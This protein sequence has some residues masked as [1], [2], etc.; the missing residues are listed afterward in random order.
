MQALGR[1]RLGADGEDAP[2]M[3]VLLRSNRDKRVVPLW[4]GIERTATRVPAPKECFGDE[5]VD[6]LA[7]E[8]R[9]TFDLARPDQAGVRHLGSPDQSFVL[10]EDVAEQVDLCDRDARIMNL[11]HAAVA[12]HG[13]SRQGADLCYGILLW[14]SDCS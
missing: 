10:V 6:V 4:T 5:C 9:F 2:L 3:A 1:R 14:S 13:V 8:H 11:V 12:V 7:V